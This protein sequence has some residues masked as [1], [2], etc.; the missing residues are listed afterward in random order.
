MEADE[1]VANGGVW[2]D[3]LCS[4]EVCV[5]LMLARLVM[6]APGLRS[7]DLSCEE[8][9]CE[10]ERNVG[11]TATPRKCSLLSVLKEHCSLR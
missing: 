8:W 6:E 2:T 11:E 5:G 3:T 4:V 7:I 10:V 9:L 1:G